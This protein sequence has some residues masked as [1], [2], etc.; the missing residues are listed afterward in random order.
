[1]LDFL[2][3]FWTLFLVNR[4]AD[5]TSGVRCGFLHYFSKWLMD[6][7]RMQKI[8]FVLIFKD[9][10]HEISQTFVVKWSTMLRKQSMEA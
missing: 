8:L 1:M 7:F 9:F 4:P 3:E 5:N 10:F 2:P 6:E